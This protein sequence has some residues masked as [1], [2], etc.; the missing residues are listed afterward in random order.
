MTETID[1]PLTGEIATT[2]ETPGGIV[3]TFRPSPPMT[4]ETLIE[5]EIKEFAM[6]EDS[7]GVIEARQRKVGVRKL[8]NDR[9][10]AGEGSFEVVILRLR[11][12]SDR[13]TLT[14]AAA[15]AKEAAD[16]AQA[17]ADAA[18]EKLR[19]SVLGWEILCR[20]FTSILEGVSNAKA[21]PDRLRASIAEGEQFIALSNCSGMEFGEVA[22]ATAN[23]VHY[24]A[25]I[26]HAEQILAGMRAKR[27]AHVAKMRAYAKD[28]DVPLHAFPEALKSHS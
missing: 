26:P 13:P 6:R 5:H 17:K 9:V 22:G 8:A 28:N 27:A 11:G 7:P 3:T 2:V 21:W 19:Q 12:G 4:F 15:K 18:A 16:V 25:L 14:A 10:A 20:D 1:R 23:I 24:T